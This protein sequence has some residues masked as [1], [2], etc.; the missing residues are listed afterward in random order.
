MVVH[1]GDVLRQLRQ[2]SEEIAV[3]M[4]SRIWSPSDGQTQRRRSSVACSSSGW[5]PRTT[6]QQQS[7]TDHGSSEASGGVDNASPLL[8]AHRSLVRRGPRNRWIGSANTRVTTTG[9]ETSAVGSP[10][11]VDPAAT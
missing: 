11:Q 9:R 6:A 5:M 4:T 10:S 3:V 1:E 2:T 7:D 8:I